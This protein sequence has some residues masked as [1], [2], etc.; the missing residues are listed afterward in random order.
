MARPLRTSSL[1]PLALALALLAGCGTNT[2][3]GSQIEQTLAPKIENQTGVRHVSVRC[4]KKVKAKA[5][6]KATCIASAPGQGILNVVIT[7]KDSE[8]NFS[9]SGQRTKR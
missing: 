7:M 9:Y 3:S 4:P 1:V 5:G 2:V 6:T 8:G